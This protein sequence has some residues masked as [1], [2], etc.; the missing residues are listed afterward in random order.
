MNI[1]V[2]GENRTHDLGAEI[3]KAAA[4]LKKKTGR[5]APPQ[6]SP[7]IGA[8]V[9]HKAGC[10]GDYLD[11]FIRLLR[12]RDAYDT[13]DFDIP[14][15]PGLVGAIMARIKKILW[16]LTR[17]QHDR[18]AFRQN[19]INGL[20]TSAIEFESDERRRKDNEINGRLARAEEMLDKLAAERR[21]E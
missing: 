2:A 21:K 5:S 9:L 18:I 12:Y 3:Q 1:I 17:Y 6:I 19:L 4:L 11:N 10:D 8:L 14:R 15:R 20:F 7:E 16:K 13:Y